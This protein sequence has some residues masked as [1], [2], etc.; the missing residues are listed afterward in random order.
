MALM[1]PYALRGLPGLSAPAWCWGAPVIVSTIP[2]GG[3][4]AIDFLAGA[5]IWA[6]IVLA[7]SRFAQA[8]HPMRVRYRRVAS[9]SLL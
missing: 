9:R 8:T 4:Y 3:H 5:A 6:A 1:T 2:I 7:A